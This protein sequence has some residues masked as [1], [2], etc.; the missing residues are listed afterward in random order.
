METFEP[1]IKCIKCFEIIESK[2]THS[3]LQ[4]HKTH[5][6]LIKASK[7]AIHVCK[8]VEICL[9]VFKHGYSNGCFSIHVFDNN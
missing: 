7:F 3:K 4:I 9:G 6:Q 8:V 2:E 1:D 5:G